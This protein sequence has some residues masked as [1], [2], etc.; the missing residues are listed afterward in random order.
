MN[1]DFIPKQN[2]ENVFYILDITLTSIQLYIYYIHSLHNSLYLL[3]LHLRHMEVSRLGVESELQ[4]PVY[5]RATAIR[6]PSCACDLITA[7]G[8][9]GS[10]SH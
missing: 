8:N 3:R 10:L 4:L 2:M 7:H 9:A 6:D 1:T 5:A